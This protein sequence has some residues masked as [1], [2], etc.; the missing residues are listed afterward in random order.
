MPT[1]CAAEFERSIERPRM[2]GPRSEIRT[3]TERPFA[4]FVTRTFVP[5]GRV[6]CAAVRPAAP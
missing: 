6:R 2:N 3:T 4:V 5:S 1:A